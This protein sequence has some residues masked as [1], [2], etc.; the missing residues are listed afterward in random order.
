MMS[1]YENSTLEELS[2]VFTE[3]THTS[4]GNAVQDSDLLSIG[5]A[6][7]AFARPGLNQLRNSMV[8]MK[9]DAFLYY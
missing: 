3:D 6:M 1:G 2:L 4:D 5:S 8:S 9:A 7:A